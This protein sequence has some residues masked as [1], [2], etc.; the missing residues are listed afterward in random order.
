MN[1]KRRIYYL[2]LL[3]RGGIIKREERPIEKTIFP[4]LGFSVRDDVKGERG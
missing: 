4:I 2:Y 3:E 1:S